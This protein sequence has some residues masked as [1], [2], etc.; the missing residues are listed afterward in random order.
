MSCYR[1]QQPGRAGTR[2]AMH[3]F[4]A[5]IED[6]TVFAGAVVAKECQAEHGVAGSLPARHDVHDELAG[7]SRLA[8][9]LKAGGRAIYPCSC[10][11]RLAKNHCGLLLSQGQIPRRDSGG[12][13]DKDCDFRFVLVEGPS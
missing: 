5:V 4:Y 9:S 2:M 10:D 7:S 6:V 13:I 11:P 12:V 1:P 8:G 3:L